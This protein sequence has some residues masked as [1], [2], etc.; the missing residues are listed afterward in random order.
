MPSHPRE[1]NVRR[2]HRERPWRRSRR[3]P[4]LAGVTALL[5]AATAITATTVSADSDEA[6]P[7]QD[8]YVWDNVRSAVVVC[9]RYRL[10]R[11]RTRPDLR[12]HRHRRCLSLG[13]V[14]RTLGTHAR[15]DRLGRGGDGP[16]SSASPPT[17]RPRPCLRRGRYLHQRLG[18]QQRR[19]PAF[20]RPG[21]DVESPSCRSNSVGTCPGVASVNDWPSTPTTT[22]PCTSAPGAATVCG[23]APTSVRPGQ[24]WRNSNPAT[25]SR[26]PTTN[27]A[28]TTTSSV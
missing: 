25:T 22:A 6:S 28:C 14:G 17:R 15:L 7:T 2:R 16:A 13:P 1:K 8:S 5:T 26:T 27:G 12:P 20:R 9:P 19:D 18:P 23:A 4:L 24:R 3:W 11:V 21:T 10:Q